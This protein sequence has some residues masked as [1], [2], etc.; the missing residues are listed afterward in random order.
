MFTWVIGFAFELPDV[1]A[2]GL[3][4]GKACANICKLSYLPSLTNRHLET[5]FDS[6][7]RVK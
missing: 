5:S 4:V 3:S 1:T 2:T 7:Q 6:L